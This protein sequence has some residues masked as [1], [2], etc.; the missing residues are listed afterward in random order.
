MSTDAFTTDLSIKVYEVLLKID[1]PIEKEISLPEPTVALYWPLQTE[2]HN[3]NKMCISHLLYLLYSF[4]QERNKAV[5]W[6]IRWD[7]YRLRS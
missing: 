4:K 7:K 1:F 6:P 3:H 2:K 5:K